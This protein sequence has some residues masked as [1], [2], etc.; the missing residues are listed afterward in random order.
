MAVLFFFLVVIKKSLSFTSFS[1]FKFL[2][3]YK[4]KFIQE[5]NCASVFYSDHII[6]KFVNILGS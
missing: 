5:E 2:F 6:S 1:Y 4:T 3:Y